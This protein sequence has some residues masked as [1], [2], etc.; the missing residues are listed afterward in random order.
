MKICKLCAL[1]KTRFMID[2]PENR[3][4]VSCWSRMSGVNSLDNKSYTPC[5]QCGTPVETDI[6]HEEL[7]MCV[8]CSHDYFSHDEE[9]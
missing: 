7:G 2:T 5:D 6:Y 9:E 8:D 4:C 1:V 3:V